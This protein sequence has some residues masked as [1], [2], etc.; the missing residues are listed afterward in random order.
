MLYGGYD[1]IYR[2]PE[3][4]GGG[5]QFQAVNP[6][7]YQLAKGAYGQFGGKIH[8]TNAP[9]L[10]NFIAG[11]AT[12]TT[13]TRTRKLTSKPLLARGNQRWQLHLPWRRRLL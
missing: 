12:S 13:I 4:G 2:S 11:S 7:Y 8:F 5:G 1:T 10:S 3:L 6:A 9:V